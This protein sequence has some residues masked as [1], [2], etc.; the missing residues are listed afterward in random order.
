MLDISTSSVLFL[1]EGASESSS[2][3]ISLYV[4][5]LLDANS[6]VQSQKNSQSEVLNDPEKEVMFVMTGNAYIIVRDS[7]TGT[8]V[9]SLPVLPKKDCIAVSMYII[10][11]CLQ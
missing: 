9:S 5:S 1:T 6:S 11:K 10:G 7:I 2:P 8:F 3:V 4:N